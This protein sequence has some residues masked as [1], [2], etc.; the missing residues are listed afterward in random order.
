MFR[1]QDFY[2]IWIKDII[3]Y[4]YTICR[5]LTIHHV[6]RRRTPVQ[7][8]K[9]HVC[10]H[11]WGGYMGLRKK[12]I[13]NIVPWE[14]GLE[15]QLKRFEPYR[16]NNRINLTLTMS[17]VERY[18]NIDLLK[19]RVDSIIPVENIGMD[20]SGY[21]TFYNLI[22]NK[23]NSYVILTNTSINVNSSDSF[24]EGYVN[25][26]EQ[27]RDVGLLGISSSSKYYHTLLRS[28]FNPHIQSFFLMTTI[29]V[30]K[31]IVEWNKG[32]FPGINETNKHL[33]IREGEVKMTQAILSLGYNAAVVLPSGPVKFNYKNYPLPKGDYR[34]YSDFPNQI[35]NI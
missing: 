30:L 17:E 19:N 4:P 12:N 11:E 14:C 16:I 35:F 24:L 22:K 25:Y 5:R 21:K 18:P 8:D 10:I 9:I 29:D 2:K 15:S 6:P 1:V 31:Q 34:N 26:L 7:T 3:L 33:L 13:K 32:K 28:N 23:P 20:F 27:N